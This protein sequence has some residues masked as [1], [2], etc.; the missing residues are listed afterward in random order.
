[1]HSCCAVDACGGGRAIAG[2]VVF[3]V[4]AGGAFGIVGFGYA[5]PR[6][7]ALCRLIP[8]PVASMTRSG[9]GDSA[10]PFYLRVF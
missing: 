3:A 2:L 10:V 5:L 6:D 1:M 4:E 7:R 9:Q 8:V